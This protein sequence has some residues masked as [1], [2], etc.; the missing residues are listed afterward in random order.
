[1]T[2]ASRV[3]FCDLRAAH[4]SRA[5]ATE[6]ALLRVARSGRY[7]LGAEVEE[8]EREFGRCCGVAH[9][10]GVGNGT[11]ALALILRASGIAAGDEVIVP[12]YTAAAT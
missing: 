1:V 5:D 6:A 10:V 11:D 7:V 4:A 9:A 8:F 2:D 3:A 12:A